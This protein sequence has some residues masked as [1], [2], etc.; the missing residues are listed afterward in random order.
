MIRVAA[1]DKTVTP[2]GAKTETTSNA[3]AHSEEEDRELIAMLGLFECAFRVSAFR[4]VLCERFIFTPPNEPKPMVTHLNRMEIRALDLEAKV[5]VRTFD[6]RVVAA[7]RSLAFDTQYSL[8]DSPVPERYPFLESRVPDADDKRA[9]AL[10]DEFAAFIGEHTLPLLQFTASN[11]PSEYDVELTDAGLETV[12]HAN[13]QTGAPLPTLPAA[14]TANAGA[15]VPP[16][17]ASAESEAA[18][19]KARLFWV[20][21]RILDRLS[22]LYSTPDFKQ[23]NVCINAICQEL[24]M[25]LHQEAFNQLIHFGMHKLLPI[26]QTPVV[27]STE[28]PAETATLVA[29]VPSSHADSSDLTLRTSS[30]TTGGDRE[31]PKRKR[32][33]IVDTVMS[34]GRLTTSSP[35]KPKLELKP[36][37]GKGHYALRL[38]AQV[39]SLSIQIADQKNGELAKFAVQRISSTL[40][41]ADFLTEFALQLSSISLVELSEVSLYKRVLAIDPGSR[42]QAD[43]FFDLHVQMNE[44]E[45][46]LSAHQR[47]QILRKEVQKEQLLAVALARNLDFHDVDLKLDI[48]RLNLIYTQRF[49][50]GS[51]KML[52]STFEALNTESV[53][54]TIHEKNAKLYGAA[55]QSFSSYREQEFRLAMD[56]NIKAPFVFVPSEPHSTHGLGLDMGN[57]SIR[58]HLEFAP[59]EPSTAQSVVAHKKLTVANSSSVALSAPSTTT[60]SASGHSGGENHPKLDVMEVTLSNF[61][62]NRMSVFLPPPPGDPKKDEV[63]VIVR[64]SADDLSKPTISKPELLASTNTPISRN[65]VEPVTVSVALRRNL[66][67]A[68]FHGVPDLQLR[69]DMPALALCASSSDL[70]LIMHTVLYNLD[71]LSDLFPK[72]KP[73][74][75][76]AAATATAPATVTTTATIHSQ[77]QQ[78]LTLLSQAP[79][80]KEDQVVLRQ[81]ECDVILVIPFITHVTNQHS[82]YFSCSPR[83]VHDM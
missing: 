64:P 1:A 36:L 33:S 48:N 2:T 38:S 70:A 19:R 13:N 74:P 12:R 29:H 32:S 79:S 71:V 61:Q 11:L 46:L 75:S 77:R 49:I 20:D 3:E 30:S 45:A 27:P 35:P 16:P 25:Q 6:T 53:R 82:Q 10:A 4:F 66:C 40:S 23:S 50:N 8:P 52:M 18:Q 21:V 14:P 67:V 42:K 43:Y 68:W 57:I 47:K 72:P 60:T 26:F 7:L 5:L 83:A 81:K 15:P 78:S 24:A 22:P 73:A 41:T 54:A 63:L 17:P 51:L 76:P 28:I 58:S 9:L 31:R 55:R 80:E 56:V 65:L 37:L 44:R 34:V 59:K 39:Q 69:I 62:I